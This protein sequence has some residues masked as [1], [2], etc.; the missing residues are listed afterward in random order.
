MDALIK[1]WRGSEK[2]SI[3]FWGYFVLGHIGFALIAGIIGGYSGIFNIPYV[4][5][6]FSILFYLPFIV[7][8]LWSVWNCAFNVEWKPWAY[9]ARG[10]TLIVV[11]QKIYY[12]VNLARY[13]HWV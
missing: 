7:W 6:L 8:S 5:I 13:N 4:A 12:L 1:A 3:V 11:I 9:I 10:V 2:L